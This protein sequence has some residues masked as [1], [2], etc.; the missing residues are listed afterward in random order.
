[1]TGRT[2]GEHGYTLLELIVVVAVSAMILVPLLAWTI[3]GFR[4]EERAQVQS[5]ETKAS[6]LLSLNVGRDL[7]EA[8]SVTRVASDCAPSGA[9]SGGEV[10]LGTVSGGA[11]PTTVVYSVVDVGGGRGEVWRR[12]CRAGS[13]LDASL[14]VEE[15]ERPFGG[16]STVVRCT[17][18]P[19]APADED[20][21]QVDLELRTP[22][23]AAVEATGTRRVEGPA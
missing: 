9:G 10:V 2:R 4:V 6:N 15:A 13:L 8:A 11:D 19:V 1:M 3:T 22:S 16:W 5:A 12:R 23:G 21:W 18:S 20:C 14:L 17:P 7:A